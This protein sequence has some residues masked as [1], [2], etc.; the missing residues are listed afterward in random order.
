MRAAVTVGVR[1]AL[2]DRRWSVLTV[3]PEGSRSFLLKAQQTVA[4]G[5]QAG[6]DLDL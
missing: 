6:A 1:P 4:F 2:G 5:V 3:C